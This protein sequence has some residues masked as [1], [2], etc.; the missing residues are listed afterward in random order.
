MGSEFACPC[1]DESTV[2]TSRRAGPQEF[3]G[4]E[5]PLQLRTPTRVSGPAISLQLRA[6][7]DG[8]AD[9]NSRRRQSVKA[10]GQAV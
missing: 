2:G 10:M 4:P 7:T 6:P 1:I 3:S 9:A 5:V 8:V